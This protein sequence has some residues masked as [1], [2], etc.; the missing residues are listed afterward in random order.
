MHAEDRLIHFSTELVHAAV[1]PDAAVL[2]KLYYELSQSVDSGYD[3]TDFSNPAQP[4]MFTRRGARTYSGL[5]CLPDRLVILEEWADSTLLAFMDRAAAV[6][7][8]YLRV[9]GPAHY[10]MQAVTLRAACA[11]SHGASARDF[12]L[13]KVCGQNRDGMGEAF[14]RPVDLGAVRFLFNESPEHP[15]T[16][17]IAI[18]PFRFGPREVLI[19]VKGIFPHQA[20]DADAMGLLQDHIRNCRSLLSQRVYPFLNGL[21]TP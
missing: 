10:T 15:G 11:I 6:A 16:F 20:L 4:K 9:V 21:D 2:K 14:G 17:H 5:V 18:E 8:T 7:S 1:K 13:E 12:V 19:E 3:N